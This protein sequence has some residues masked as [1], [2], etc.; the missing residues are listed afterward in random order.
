MV[1]CPLCGW[2]YDPSVSSSCAACPLSRGCRVS[3]CP[4]CGYSMPPESGLVRLWRRVRR[5]D[6]ERGE[7]VREC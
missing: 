6:G 5:K 3:C 1:K 4:N 2:A 7:W